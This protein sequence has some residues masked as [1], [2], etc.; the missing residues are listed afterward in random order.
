[1]DYGSLI[2]LPNKPKCGECIISLHCQAFKTNLTHIIPLKKKKPNEKLKKFTRAYII[3]NEYNNILVRRRSSSG[4]LQS[5]LEVP[6]DNWV[7]NKKL[8]K[9]D[10]TAKLVSIKFYKIIGEF[11]YSFSHFHLN[12]EIFYTS[13]KKRKI[14]NHFWISLNK[15]VDLGMPTLMKKIMKIYQSSTNC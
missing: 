6:N 3:V 11:N 13:I 1:M 7:M 15:I 9:K 8:L 4:M 10:K 2:C 12:V 14:E 5:M